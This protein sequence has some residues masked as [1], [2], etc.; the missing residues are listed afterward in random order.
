MCLQNY[1]IKLFQ[2]N[3]N[4]LSV[5]SE[6]Y[7]NRNEQ[8]WTKRCQ[9]TKEKYKAQ[10]TDTMYNVLDTLLMNLSPLQYAMNVTANLNVIS[11]TKL[12][13][14]SQSVTGPSLVTY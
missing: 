9:C 12:A 14:V 13:D 5:C 1:T 3:L 2:E 6:F 11:G 10:I 8:N 7:K 4:N